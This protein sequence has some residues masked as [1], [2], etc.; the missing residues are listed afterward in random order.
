[1]FEFYE[2]E[3][4]IALAAAARGGH[5]RDLRRAAV[6]PEEVAERRRADEQDATLFLVAAFTGLRLG[7]LHLRGAS[8]LAAA[9]D[10]VQDEVPAGARYAAGANAITAPQIRQAVPREADHPHLGVKLQELLTAV[11]LTAN[12]DAVGV[13][14]DDAGNHRVPLPPVAARAR[15]SLRALVAA[16]HTAVEWMG[17]QRKRK[18]LRVVGVLLALNRD[19]HRWWH[20]AEPMDPNDVG[21]AVRLRRVA[22]ATRDPPAAHR[23]SR[24]YANLLVGEVRDAAPDDAVHAFHAQR[25]VAA[26]AARGDDA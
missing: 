25:A 23:R 1:M 21:G 7:E 19:C 9:A 22:T 16:V 10:L 8:G 2:P 20:R 17:A 3:E 18:A 5:H 4:V 14:R 26:L 11:V 15:G 12:D 6:T 24:R 13:R